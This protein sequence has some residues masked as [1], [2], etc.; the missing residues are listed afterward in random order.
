M[1]LDLELFR[2]ILLVVEESHTP[3]VKS[4]YSLR[5]EGNALRFRTIQG[6]FISC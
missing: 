5:F 1:R 3:T 2:A 4:N 6:Y